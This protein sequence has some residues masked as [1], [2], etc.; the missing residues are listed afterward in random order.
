MIGSEN[1]IARNGRSRFKARSVCHCLRSALIVAVLVTLFRLSSAE[2][3]EA[4]AQLVFNGKPAQES[5]YSEVQLL[6]GS[7]AG[8]SATQAVCKSCSRQFDLLARATF[9]DRSKVEIIPA[10]RRFHDCPESLSL[11]GIYT[12]PSGVVV[13]IVGTLR[14]VG[15]QYTGL[16]APVAGRQYSRSIPAAIQI[17]GLTL[18]QSDKCL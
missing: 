8:R 1:C 12:A 18:A 13:P 7:A 10:R 14:L 17:W 15:D 16:V 5:P 3:Q 9:V 6:L 4:R 2:S 11:E